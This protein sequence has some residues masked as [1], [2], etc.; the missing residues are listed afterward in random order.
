[1]TPGG[2]CCP[3]SDDEHGNVRPLPGESSTILVPGLDGLPQGGSGS[4]QIAEV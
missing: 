1:M 3:R 4:F 2:H